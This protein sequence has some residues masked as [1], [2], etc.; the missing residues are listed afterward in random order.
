MTRAITSLCKYSFRKAEETQVD[1]GKDGD[2]NNHEE[3]TSLDSVWPTAE[4]EAV[5]KAGTYACL[6]K[7]KQIN[8]LKVHVVKVKVTP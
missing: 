6:S 1:Q 4:E 7:K 3:L 5:C 8:T 2:T